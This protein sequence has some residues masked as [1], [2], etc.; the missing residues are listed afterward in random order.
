MKSRTNGMGLRN[1]SRILVLLASLPPLLAV[2]GTA[3]AESDCVA[4]P[5]ILREVE[6][7]LAHSANAQAAGSGA[8][9]IREVLFGVTDIDAEDNGELDAREQVQ[10][11]R[12]TAS[13]GDYTNSGPKK[14]TIEGIFAGRET[15]FRL[16]KRIEGSYRLDSTGATLTYDPDFAVDVGERIIGI[17][18]F[19]S[20]H[21]MTVSREKLAFYFAGNDGTDP[22]RCYLVQ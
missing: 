19:M 18:L 15:L 11:T 1:R 6:T 13:G 2:A 5:G 16:P 10:M 14:V 7:F 12:R 9:P 20:V 3:L 21:R 4:V 8:M 22:D 17:P